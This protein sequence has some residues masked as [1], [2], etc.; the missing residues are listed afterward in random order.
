MNFD[1]GLQCLVPSTGF[2]I[3]SDKSRSL[4]T[5][6]HRHAHVL[7]NIVRYR[8]SEVVSTSHDPT[9]SCD[10]VTKSLGDNESSNN[11]VPSFWILLEAWEEESNVPRVRGGKRKTPE[12]RSSSM[13]SW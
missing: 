9:S 13:M 7:Q 12:R 11:K 4:K 6:H 5:I 8:L 1:P 10:D 2:F 3:R